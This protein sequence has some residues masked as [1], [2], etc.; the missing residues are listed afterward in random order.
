MVELPSVSMKSRIVVVSIIKKGN[1]ILLGR[2][3]KGVGPYPD[4]WHIPGGGV[5]LE[6][7]DC[8]SAIKREIKEE[9]GLEVDNLEKISWD[10][11]IEKDKKGIK[12]YYIFLQY[13]STYKSGNINPGDDMKNFEWV[14]LKKLSKYNLNRPTKILFKKL[15]YIK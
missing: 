9:T 3:P 5:N 4:T 15:G 11:D 10:T 7:E 2:K 12:T 14:D 13:A 6:K 8:D 1:Q